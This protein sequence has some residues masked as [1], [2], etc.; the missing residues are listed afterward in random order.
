MVR[1]M[2]MN[3]LSSEP[4]LR[5]ARAR[6]A[7]AITVLMYHELLGD[8]QP[9]EAWTAIKVSEFRQ[10]MHYLRTH[11]DVLSIDEALVRKPSSRP[12]AVVTFDD[13]GAGNHRYLLPL[14]EQLSLPVAV[15][16]ATG[17]VE[18]G[19]SFWFDR[20]MNALQVDRRL[21]VDLRNKG[22]GVYTVT[23]PSGA[24]NWVNIQRLLSDIKA[25]GVERN[26]ELADAVEA[27]V[28]EQGVR[29]S[30]PLLPMSIKQVHELA[31]SR[32]VTIGAHSHT[33]SL[34]TQLPNVELVADIIRSRQLLQEWTGQSV[35]HF[36]YPSGANDARVRNEVAACGF[37]SAFT[38]AE[39]LWQP[40]CDHLAIPRMGLGRYDA[41]SRFKVAMCGGPGPLLRGLL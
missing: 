31:S 7:A 1:Q 37:R 11:F 27:R 13:G 26:D 25:A 41:F 12:A 30:T 21:E 23:A 19:R 6:A 39:L 16:V 36:A 8:D 35:S 28:T 29:R 20:V 3:A 18:S 22:L 4:L 2:V 9:V 40:G 34:L 38:T 5:R 33:H 15:F 17:H 24:S 10:Q 32:F 14:V